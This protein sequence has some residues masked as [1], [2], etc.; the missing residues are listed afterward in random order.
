MG[1]FRAY[2][3]DV[4]LQIST[5]NARNSLCFCILYCGLENRFANRWYEKAFSQSPIQPDLE[6][7]IMS[8]KNDV[9]RRQFISTVASTAAVSYLARPAFSFGAFQ[10]GGDSAGLP[11]KD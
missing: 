5:D 3:Q 9:S 7:S 2:C 1:F 8:P 11:W 6:E 10:G 4:R